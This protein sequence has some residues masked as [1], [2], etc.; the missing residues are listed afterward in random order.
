MICGS[1][2]SQSII[3]VLTDVFQSLSGHNSPVECVRFSSSEE[4]V[5]AGSQ[6]GSLKIWD[7][8]AAKSKYK[9]GSGL[10]AEVI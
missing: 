6:S 2:R 5:A 7:L 9:R 10:L 1:S 4:L 8:E 3:I